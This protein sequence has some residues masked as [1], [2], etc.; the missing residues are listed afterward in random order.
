MPPVLVLV[1]VP[2]RSPVQLLV[3]AAMS[4]SCDLLLHV[5]GSAHVLL[6]ISLFSIAGAFVSTAIHNILGD[7]VR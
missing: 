3:R 4:C 1:P 2:M 5:G 7:E 6:V